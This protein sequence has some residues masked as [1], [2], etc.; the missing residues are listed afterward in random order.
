MHLKVREFMQKAGQNTP[1]VP[2]TPSDEERYLRATL[3]LEEALETINKGLGI[4]VRVCGNSLESSEVSLEIVS[5]FDM[6]ETID[7]AED[8]RWVGVD[9]IYVMCGVDPK[10][11]Q[12]EVCESNLSKFLDGYRREDGK[13]MKG[14]S[15][16]PVDLS[17]KI[18]PIVNK[19]GFNL[20]EFYVDCGRMG[21]LCGT[22]LATKKEIDALIGRELYFSE[23]LGKYSEIKVVFDED[24]FSLLEENVDKDEVHIS[25]ISPFRGMCDDYGYLKTSREEEYEKF[26]E[27]CKRKDVETN[28]WDIDLIE[29][30]YAEKDKVRA[31]KEKV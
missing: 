14:P 23:V 15:Y 21:D 8:L 10:K 1:D 29:E 9:G 12:K 25:G 30:F 19:D 27:W 26:E 31:I 28:P 11:P 6:I 5:D 24:C 3:I 2:T 18:F 20:Y 22:F 16:K 4:E 13:W 7:G 17:N